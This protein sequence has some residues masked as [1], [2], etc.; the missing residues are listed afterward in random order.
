M[1]SSLVNEPRLTLRTVFAVGTHPSQILPASVEWQE[2]EHPLPDER[3]V[4]AGRRAQAIAQDVLPDEMLLLLLSGGAS[5]VLALPAHGITLDDKRRTIEIMMKTGADIHALNTVRKHLSAIKGGQLAAT[6]RGT[7]RT[8]ALSDVVDDD[9][10][11]IG[12]GPGVADATTW[13]DVAA[14]LN[15]FGGSAHPQ[16]VLHRVE[17]GLAAR[18]S[19]TPKKTDS[20]LMRAAG[21]VI[22]S[23]R[24]ALEGAWKTASSLGYQAVVLPDAVIGEAREAANRWYATVQR[25]AAGTVGPLCVISAG[26][27]TVTVRGGGKGGRNQEFALAVAAALQSSDAET[28]AVSVGTDGIDGPTDVAGAIVDR[29]TLTRGGALGLDPVAYLDAND[30]YAF[31]EPLGDLI[32]I[33]RTDTNVGDLQ[34]FLRG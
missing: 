33:G 2:A 29:T 31:F 5:A 6:C 18:V 21:H 17:A 25:I 14:A 13:T 8:L 10:S 32:R 3:S 7:T 30:S 11:V 28:V 12:S 23:R 27:T 16:A 19:D 26:E 22:A 9:V 15:Q 1:V 24:D 4:F 20:G 34:I